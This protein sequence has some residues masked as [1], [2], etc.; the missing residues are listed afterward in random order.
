MINTL[1]SSVAQLDRA[2]NKNIKFRR[3]MLYQKKLFIITL[4][5]SIFLFLPFLSFADAKENMTLTSH[6][7]IKE[8]RLVKSVKGVQSL[9]LEQYSSMIL[10]MMDF[11]NLLE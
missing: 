8:F 7:I 11:A 6:Q 4:I 1:C 10:I 3:H 9:I 2:S 5:K